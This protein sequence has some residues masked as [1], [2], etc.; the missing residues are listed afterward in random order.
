MKV[1]GINGSPRHGSSSARMLEIALGVISEQE[2]IDT[3][4][5]N[6][7]DYKIQHCTGC[8][9]CLKAECPLD[10]G[11][12]FP[13]IHDKLVQASAIIIA[14]PNY[15]LNVPGI[16]KDFIDRSRRMKMN[17]GELKNI[18][19]GNLV[20][21]G[22]RN[23]GG[24][25]VSM[26]LNSWAISQG[27]IIVGNLGNH[28]IENPMAITT[29]QQDGLKSFRKPGADDEIGHKGALR[30]GQRIVEL[31]SLLKR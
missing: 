31:L 27:M 7:R 3:E 15:F 10:D 23:G 1:L 14:S 28:V 22:L 4:I 25:I 30:L 13:S 9:T 21:T 17:R 6:I 8:D 20:S 11:D 12:D 5:M 19:F 16:L 29:L 2:S 24:E 18:I 26:L